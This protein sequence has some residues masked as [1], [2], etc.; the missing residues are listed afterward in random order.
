MLKNEYFIRINKK[1]S[2]RFRFWL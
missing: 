1:I 2:Y